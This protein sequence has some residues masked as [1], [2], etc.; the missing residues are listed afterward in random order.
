VGISVEAV[1]VNC[2]IFHEY[3]TSEVVLEDPEIG[4]TD[5]NIPTK[6]K[7]VHDEQYF[8]TTGDRGDN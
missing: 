1:H 4:S 3:F 7:C 2:A 5:P 8:G 6:Y